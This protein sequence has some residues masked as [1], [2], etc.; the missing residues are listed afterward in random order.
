MPCFHFSWLFY[1]F[2]F[3]TQFNVQCAVPENVPLTGRGGGGASQDIF[4]TYNSWLRP[5]HLMVRKV[6]FTIKG[7]VKIVT[8]AGV[9]VLAVTVSIFPQWL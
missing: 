2:L 4:G 3:Y 1:T 5:R 8:L 6:Y 7:V 9:I